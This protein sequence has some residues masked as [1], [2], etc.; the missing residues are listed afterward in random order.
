MIDKHD[1]RLLAFW[2]ALLCAAGSLVTTVSVASK[3]WR[4]FEATAALGITAV[5]P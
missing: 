5:L 1:T 4:G 2:I 3:S